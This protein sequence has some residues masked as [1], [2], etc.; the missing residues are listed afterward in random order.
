[1]HRGFPAARYAATSPFMKLH[2]FI[3]TVFTIF[4]LAGSLAKAADNSVLY[5]NGQALNATR[6][7]RNPPPMS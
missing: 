5:W 4:A 2:R 3:L 7:A 6:L 1:M